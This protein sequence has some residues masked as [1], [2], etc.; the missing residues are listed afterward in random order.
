[1]RFSIFVPWL[2]N[3]TALKLSFIY[4][5]P[6]EFVCML[7]SYMFV[8]EMLD[9]TCL[10]INFFNRSTAAQLE[11]R[12]VKTASLC[13]LLYTSKKPHF[14]VTPAVFHLAELT[15]VMEWRYPHT[16]HSGWH[17][18]NMK[19]SG[20]GGLL[21]LPCSELLLRQSFTT[22]IFPPGECVKPLTLISPYGQTSQ[23]PKNNPRYLCTCVRTPNARV[24]EWLTRCLEGRRIPVGSG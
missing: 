21:Q 19:E 12:Q 23:S 8:C 17:K 7:Y 5:H 1:M 14:G 20:P 22:E 9:I 6:S 11:M 3:D 16:H 18:I 15:L 4:Q 13:I 24:I 10:V 2:D